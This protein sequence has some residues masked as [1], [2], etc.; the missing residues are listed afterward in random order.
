MGEKVLILH[1]DST[2]SRVFSRWKGPATIVQVV[3]PYSYLVEIDGARR[4]YHA[5]HLRKFHL[6]VNRVTCGPLIVNAISHDSAFA[7]DTCA[8]VREEDHN[9]G[10]IHFSKPIGNHS[11]VELIP[12]QR[13][14]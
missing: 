14:D 12:S 13:I 2:A 5:N 3:S 8:I 10:Q 11:K 7:I 1:K 6:Q 9:F 4:V